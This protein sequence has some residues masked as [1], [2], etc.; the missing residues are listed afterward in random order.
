MIDSFGHSVLQNTPQIVSFIKNVLDLSTREEKEG[1]N[2]KSTTQE[3]DNAFY[4]GT[5]DLALMLLSTLLASN[6][7]CFFYYSKPYLSNSN[8]CIA[9][10]IHM[11]FVFF[12]SKCLLLNQTRIC[13]T[14]MLKTS[15]N[16]GLAYAYDMLKFSTFSIRCTKVWEMTAYLDYFSNIYQTC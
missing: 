2:K 5:I 1:S 3:D 11:F 12:I 15:M 13:L 9:F 16:Q 14:Y 8:I 6:Q 10:F 7:V 4:T